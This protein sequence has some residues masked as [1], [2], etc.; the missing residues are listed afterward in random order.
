MSREDD[1]EKEY[2]KN[3]NKARN[4]LKELKYLTE[5]YGFYIENYSD[6][7]DSFHLKDLKNPDLSYPVS[8]DE[9]INQYNIHIE[10]DLPD[11]TED[12]ETMN[13]YFKDVKVKNETATGTMLNKKHYEL[14]ALI[15]AIGLGRVV[16]KI[17]ARRT[18][19]NI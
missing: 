7:W 12:L 6:Y 19:E 15:E 13:P 14:G 17:K 10:E 1:L 5:K 2:K 8:Y 4:F 16:K 9:N 18:N 11:I 3:L